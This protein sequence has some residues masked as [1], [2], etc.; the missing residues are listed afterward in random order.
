MTIGSIQEIKERKIRIHSSFNDLVTQLKSVQFNEKGHP[1]KT[2]LSFDMG[3]AFMMA[4]NYFRHIDV[5]AFALE[6]SF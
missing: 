5:G 2:K 1:D 3:D 4:T 6:G